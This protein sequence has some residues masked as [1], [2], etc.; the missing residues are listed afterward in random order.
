M[1]WMLGFFLLTASLVCLCAA[2]LSSDCTSAVSS[3][4]IALSND[5]DVF[6]QQALE[7]PLLCGKVADPSLDPMFNCMDLYS[8]L[9][10]NDDYTAYIRAPRSLANPGDISCPLCS[11]EM[12]VALLPA[13][14]SLMQTILEAATGSTITT[15]YDEVSMDE[16]VASIRSACGNSMDSWLLA[17][18]RYQSEILCASSK[19]FGLPMSGINTTVGSMVTLFFINALTLQLSLLMR[20]APGHEEYHAV[21]Y[22]RS[23]GLHAWGIL[24]RK[25]SSSSMP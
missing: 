8:V 14:A 10:L 22:M 25:C 19:S 11:Q 20:L 2:L 4:S 12:D 3:F 18:V 7:N 13:C 15:S 23:D 21:W 24:P 16:E 9:A 5:C 17:F 6:L 1:A